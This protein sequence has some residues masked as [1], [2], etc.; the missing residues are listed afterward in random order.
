MFDL[1][2]E[3]LENHPHYQGKQLDNAG[4]CVIFEG[5]VRQV[6]HDRQVKH[7]EYEG[8]DELAENE[9]KKIAGEVFNKFSILDV[10]CIHRVGRLEVGERA[11][12]VSVQAEHRGAAFEACRY[13][14]DEL[15]RRLPVWK[16]EHYTDG[17]SG[18]INT[19]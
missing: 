19:P 4:A 12:W 5:W 17:D 6:N 16:K 9:F 8:A 14:I 13:V 2:A 18:W 1:S 7:L 10:S 15:K 11:V 3:P